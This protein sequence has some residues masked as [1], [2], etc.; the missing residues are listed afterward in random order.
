MR[1]IALSL[2]LAVAFFGCNKNENCQRCMLY[3]TETTDT[4][5]A[6]KYHV[7]TGDTEFC[8]YTQQDQIRQLF[9]SNHSRADTY[10]V[11]KPT[12]SGRKNYYLIYTDKKLECNNY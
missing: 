8:N 5:T 6:V 2:F 9:L 12:A 3:S 1:T 10:N 7:F 11:A 4:G